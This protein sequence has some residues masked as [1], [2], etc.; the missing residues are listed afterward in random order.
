MREPLTNLIASIPSVQSGAGP[1]EVTGDNV[2]IV[3]SISPDYVWPDLVRDVESGQLPS[4]LVL[5]TAPGAMG[6]SAAARAI[7]SRTRMPYVDLARVRVGSGSLTGELAKALGFKAM[8]QFVDDLKAGRAALILDSNDEA[9]MT[10][11]RENYLAFLTDLAWLLL[12]AE[13]KNQVILLGRRDATETTI[14][15]LMELGLVPPVYQ[16]APLSKHQAAGLVALTLDLKRTAAGAPFAV[17]RQHGTPFGELRDALF[18]DLGKALDPTLRHG[19]DYW[20]SVSD[21]LG[22]PPVV[23][24]LAERLAVDN[25]GAALES[26]KATPP[27]EEPVLRGAL[28]RGVLE[29]I[30][31]RESTKV[32]ARVGE[33]LAIREDSPERAVLY[34]HDEQ[35]ARLLSLTGTQGV[36]VEQPASLDEHDRAK[37]EELIDSFVLDHPFVSGGRFVNVVFSDYVRAWAISS[38][39]SALYAVSRAE[40]FASLPKPGPFFAHF[41]HAL[42]ASDPSVDPGLVPE[43]VVDD[44]IH[45]FMLGTDGGSAVYVHR[46]EH[47]ILFLHNEDTLRDVDPQ[48]LAFQVTEVGGVLVLSSPMAR[49]LCVTDHSVLLRGLNGSFDFGPEAS[50]VTDSLEIDAVSFTALG[51][52]RGGNLL[53]NFIGARE[54]EHPA[55]LRVGAVPDR[56][57]SVSWPD[58]WHQWKAFAIETSGSKSVPPAI[59][60]QV[61]LC[62]R[63]ILTS[64]KSSVRADPSVSADKMDRVIIG[65]NPVFAAVLAALIGLGLVER[66]GSLYRVNLDALA[67]YEVSWSSLRGDDPAR[68]LLKVSTAVVNRPELLHYLKE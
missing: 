28:L 41:L 10:S 17:H 68:A 5:I 36:R 48:G 53:W 22:Y 49:V 50:V 18:W 27:S 57:L 45:S 55:E 16:I 23:N 65:S 3:E 7:A 19:Q 52:N 59:A 8:G 29:Q 66:E 61:L 40:F 26:F 14:L 54:V 21:F 43:D 67:S 6:K 51:D 9:Q 12:D 32:R 47:A 34:G 63:R 15:A 58:Y 13:P 30:M 1:I 11:G 44:V 56:S 24:A 38:T 31:A 46:G 37:Y 33:A 42:S 39:I 20:E 64:F 60:S 2:S 25:P 62:L 35:A 4:P